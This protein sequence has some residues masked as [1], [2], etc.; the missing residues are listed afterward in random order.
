MNRLLTV[1]PSNSPCPLCQFFKSLDEKQRQ[2]LLSLF[3]ML[4]QAPQA[5]MREPYTKHFSL[6][7]YQSLYELRAKSKTLVRIIFTL[8]DEGDV[9]FL[10]PFIKRHKRD[11]M[12]ALDASLRLM[13]GVEDVT[14]S[15]HELSLLICLRNAVRTNMNRRFYPFSLFSTQIRILSEKAAAML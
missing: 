2:K 15:T 13:A 14:S 12:Q 5:I 11:T 10:A 7:R 3:I 9:L 1:V 4:L 6:E 8:T